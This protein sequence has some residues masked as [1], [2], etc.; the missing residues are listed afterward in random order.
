MLIPEN[1]KLQRRAAHLSKNLPVTVYWEFACQQRKEVYSEMFEFKRVQFSI[2]VK[3][4]VI[5]KAD[6]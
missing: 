6:Y 5:N 4:L 3:R 1:D 2:A